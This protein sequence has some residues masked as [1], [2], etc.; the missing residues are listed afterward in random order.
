MQNTPTPDWNRILTPAIRPAESTAS[1]SP[2]NSANSAD[3][4][5][6][7]EAWA[8]S[9]DLAP[10]TALALVGASL[11]NIAGH[12]LMF[13]VP[14]VNRGAPGINLVGMAGDIL[15]HMAIAELLGPFKSRQD[16]LLL[17]AHEFSA[18]EIDFAMF[19]HTRTSVAQG[20][21]RKLAA[22]EP[23]DAYD[24]AFPEQQLDQAMEISPK[25]VKY[26]ALVKPRFMIYGPTPANP[27]KVLVECHCGL[28]F[29]VGGVE[30]LPA[31]TQRNRR[32]DELL[33]FIRG[34][35][36]SSPAA[37]NQTKISIE[38]VRLCGIFMFQTP[39]FAWL[40][41]QRRD[42]LCH[43]IPVGSSPASEQEPAVDET[44]ADGFRRLFDQTAVHVLALRR[45]FAGAQGWFRRNDAATE[46]A[47]QQRTFLRQLQQ[48]PDAYRIDEIAALPAVMAWAL[49]MLGGRQD[50]DQYVLETAFEAAR[51]VNEDA[52]RM[53]RIHEQSAISE[54]RLATARKLVERLAR[55]G[56]CKRRELVRGFK[57]QSLGFHEPVLQVLLN[58]GI[59]VESPGRVLSL[60][61]VPAAQLDRQKF[62]EL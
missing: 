41:D 33:K 42:F 39:H 56:S 18:A 8:A 30:A 10:H 25:T 26:Q 23:Q 34:A 3:D 51:R 44:R 43:A 22:P 54:Q 62:I 59:F 20:D 15:L 57:Q 40:V 24:S 29:C 4:P 1:M 48:Q 31:G 27:A 60:G 7:L 52:V 21:L 5:L 28:G 14:S 16:A 12:S 49:L 38:T 55:L 53:I 13:G 6:G 61:Q 36:T 11:A 35:E 2:A 9:H 32:V 17:K 37:R 47:R 58:I 46:F 45:A 19:L 50:L